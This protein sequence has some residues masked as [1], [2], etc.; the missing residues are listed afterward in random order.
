MSTASY[1]K[2]ET[3][4]IMKH[5]F[6]MQLAIQ[7]AKKAGQ[8]DEVPIGTVVAS[9]NGEVLAVE[10]NR[11]IERCDPCAHAEILALRQAAKKIGNYRLLDTTLYVTIEPCIMCM[12]ALI[13][14]RASTV[15]FGAHDP[16]WGACGSIFDFSEDSRL[17]HRVTVIP[18]ICAAECR[19]L[20]QA[21]FRNKRNSDS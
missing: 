20:I 19:E 4:P 9:K 2:T 11:V 14:A 10:R 13:H 7:A 15:V 8:S 5:E 17:N 6:F 1:K 12:G 21:F 3:D 16:K 18:G